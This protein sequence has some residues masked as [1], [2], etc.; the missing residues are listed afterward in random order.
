VISFSVGDTN[1]TALEISPGTMTMFAGDSREITVTD[2][3][4]NGGASGRVVG[5]DPSVAD[6]SE[7]DGSTLVTALAA[8]QTTLS[9][10]FQGHTAYA[11]GVGIRGGQRMACGQLPLEPERCRGTWRPEA[12]RSAARNLVNGRC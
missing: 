3:W 5:P 4:G 2:D 9:V 11:H 1:V 7:S 8:G 12:W 6:V 10:T